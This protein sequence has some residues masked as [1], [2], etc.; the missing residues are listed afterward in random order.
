MRGV[1]GSW[2]V[3]LLFWGVFW[4]FPSPVRVLDCW[5]LPSARFFVFGNRLRSLAEDVGF[6]FT[7]WGVG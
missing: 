5:L 3:S 7:R 1:V 4:F 6:P 2:V